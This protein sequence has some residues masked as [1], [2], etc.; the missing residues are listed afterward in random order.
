MVW[1]DKTKS[2]KTAPLLAASLLAALCAAPARAQSPAPQ[3]ETA[4]G[5]EMP[6][7]YFINRMTNPSRETIEETARE[8][9]R[10]AYSR[11]PDKGPASV[12][13]GTAASLTEAGR[14]PPPSE[15]GKGA[16]SVEVA[17]GQ[18]T[19]DGS[20]YDPYPKQY[21]LNRMFGASGGGN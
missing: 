8:E 15:A 12:A 13:A 2:G 7:Q 3:A 21:L 5:Q 4:F 10:P 18:P 16:P 19:S 14:G 11:A 6:K 20:Y 1:I 17:G 9:A